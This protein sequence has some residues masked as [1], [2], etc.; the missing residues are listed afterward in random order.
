MKRKLPLLIFYSF[1]IIYLELVYKSAVLNNVFSINTLTVIVFSI[2][3]ILINTLISSLFKEKINRIISVVLS[4][5]ITLIYIS[6]Y[7][8][9]EFYDSIFSIY[10][11]KEGTG[12]VFGEFFSAILKMVSDNIWVTLLFLLP[13]LLFIIFGKKIFNFERNKKASLITSGL[14]IVSIA[15]CI[16]FVQFYGSGMY[17]LK[18]LY[19][20][21]H[22]PMITINKVGLLSMEVLDLDRF[23]FDFEEKLYNINKPTDNKEETKKP[24]ETEEIKYNVL[25]IDFDKLINEEEN[26]MVKSMHEYFKN[27]TPTK[28][29]EYT[30]IFKGKNLIYIT[31]EGFDK[32]A[33]DENLTPTLY[34]LA[35][36]GFVF[37]NYYQP[38]FTVSTSDGEYMFLNSLIPKEGVWSFYR[39]SNIYLPFG[40]GNVFKRE[41]YSTVNAYHD[42]T[43][44]YY[45]RDKSHPNL[46]FDKYIG[47]G[48]GLEELINCK[49]WP[50]SDVEMINATVDD[51]INSDNFMTYYMT[52]SGHLNY[53]FTGNYISYK[54]KDLVKDLPYTDHVKAYLAAN[55]ELDRAIESLINKLKEKGKLDDTVIVIS[56]DHYPYGLKTSELNEISDTDRSD[57]FEMFHTSLIL[58]NSE[59][60]ENVKVI[61]YVSSIDVL[62]TIYNLFGIKYDSRLLM[63]RDA[64]SD[65]EGLV[66]LSDRSFINEFGSYNSITGKYTKFKEDV[67]NDYIEKLN[68]EVYQRFTMS[69]LLLYEKNG[70]YLD[71]YRKLGLY[72]D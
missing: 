31:A 49:T 66:I 44:T 26:S 48:N 63:G 38:L 1:L 64:L 16:L 25:D 50:E 30:G 8:Y 65:A 39:S 27:V 57:K 33:I 5:F 32:I 9:F 40:I 18:R 3:F 19:K 35:N 58:Y 12:Q 14:S 20:E 13:F 42:H 24:E 6:Q 37:E 52:V 71:Y 60:E 17:S 46:G 15:I 2:P 41:G 47:C 72:E 36:N 54:N 4:I 45:N 53:T 43:Y 61:K 21:T 11:I 70:V 51:Y 67:S 62:P 10:S 69:S 56:P 28:Q 29:N 7:I 59:I 34:K 68:H 55:I 22:A 23:I